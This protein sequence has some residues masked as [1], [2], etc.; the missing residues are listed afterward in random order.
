MKINHVFRPLVAL[1]VAAVSLSS[2]K[3]DNPVHEHD[4]EEISRL[5]LQFTPTTG[6]AAEP[7]TLVFTTADNANKEVTLKKGSYTLRIKAQ[8]FDGHD[9]TQEFIESAAEHQFFFVGPTAQQ[10]SYSYLDAN[11]GISGTWNNLQAASG[12]PVQVTLM[13]GLN[14]SKVSASDWNNPNYFSLAGGTRDIAVSFN[15]IITE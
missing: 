1:L 9:I 14:K 8:D 6:M 11:V 3:K 15:L 12:I 5:E 13:H 7:Q 4:N 2:C 10:V